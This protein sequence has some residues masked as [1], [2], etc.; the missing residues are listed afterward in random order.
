MTDT[1]TGL[2]LELLKKVLTNRIQMDTPADWP[3][4]SGADGEEARPAAFSAHTMVSPES[5]DN[6]QYCVE[7]ALADG[8]PG[9][10][11]ETGVW[12]GGICVLMRA[13]LKAHGVKD[14]RVWVADSFEGV[15]EAGDGSHPLDQEMALHN[16]NTVLSV[17]ADAVRAVFASYGLLDDQV[18]FLE[19]WFNETLPAAPIESLAVLRLDGDLYVSTM[20]S[21]SALYPKLSP[22]GF[23][24]I[25]DYNMAPCR[26]AVHEYRDA[27]GIKEEIMAADS[28]GVWWRKES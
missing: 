3:A 23:V 20:D 2:Y 22:G 24:I 4:G 8:V 5:L 26:A 19:G 12:R 13:I 11:I 1:G 9:D 21:L 17:P 27:H 7:T 15:P 28:V 25:D 6:V 10:L 16:L 18:E 14:R